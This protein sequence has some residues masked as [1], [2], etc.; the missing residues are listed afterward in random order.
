MKKYSLAL[1]IFL[2]A[3]LVM[4]VW[5]E[6]STLYMRSDTQTF[7]GVT[8]YKLSETQS[9][10]ST[11]D[12]REKLDTDTH[13]I[14]YGVTIYSV[15]WNETQTAVTSTVV[16]I[17]T[18]TSDG[19]GIQT[20]SWT[21]DSPLVLDA[22]LVRVYQRFGAEDWSLRASFIMFE[23]ASIK[24]PTFTFYYYTERIT[25]WQ[26]I[27][28]KWNTTSV[29]RWGSSTYNSRIELDYTEPHPWELQLRKLAQ[30]NIIAFIE[31]PYTYLLGNLAYGF[32]L[33]GLGLTL[34][35][36]HESIVPASLAL[37]LFGG[38]GGIT[39]MLI[40]LVGLHLGWLVFVFGLGILFFK[41]VKGIG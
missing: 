27:P 14:S 17:V 40:P 35:K 38:A 16:A 39:T 41:L 6:T 5:A 1:T 15:D 9:S 12:S 32:F 2:L 31:F 4:P 29:F 3:C 34:Y 36:R 26:P 20:V 11:I 21:Y 7:R 25:T 37:I 18:R 19:A 10:T 8:G 33:L 22:L 23:D 13:N 28:S 24:E 30:I